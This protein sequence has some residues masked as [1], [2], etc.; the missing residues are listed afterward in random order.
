M[1]NVS[2]QLFFGVFVTTSSLYIASEAFKKVQAPFLAIQ[3]ILFRKAAS[4]LE[5]QVKQDN[6]K[7]SLVNLPSEIWDMIKFELIGLE[8]AESE[9]ELLDRFTCERC[10]TMDRLYRQ[11]RKSTKYQHPAVTTWKDFPRDGCDACYDGFD[12]D[13]RWFERGL[14]GDLH[15]RIPTLSFLN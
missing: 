11:F 3:L 6:S 10:K 13:L 2:T 5:V 8:L 14:L 9:R 7:L 15:V 1:S 12:S 4:T